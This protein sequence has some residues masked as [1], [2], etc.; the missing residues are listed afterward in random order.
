ML[1]LFTIGTVAG[2]MFPGAGFCAETSCKPSA[3]QMCFD[4]P[5]GYQPPSATKAMKPSDQKAA[6]LPNATHDR[7]LKVDDDTSFGLG[8]R[9]LNLKRSF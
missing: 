2:I 1:R 4:L 6:P 3:T 9:G 7:R 8:G 5:A